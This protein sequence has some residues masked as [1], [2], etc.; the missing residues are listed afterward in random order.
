MTPRDPDDGISL[1]PP[2]LLPKHEIVGWPTSCCSSLQIAAFFQ[3][4]D[5]LWHHSI[6]EV[7]LPYAQQFRASPSLVDRLDFCRRSDGIEF[8]GDEQNPAGIA[9]R[10]A[11]Q[12]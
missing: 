4:V 3:P 12:R 5:R 11:V 8:A 2:Q 10:L 9:Y 1:S 7:P 6:T